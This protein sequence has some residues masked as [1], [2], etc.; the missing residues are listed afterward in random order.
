MATCKQIEHPLGCGDDKCC[1]ECN[2]R[3]NMQALSG[4]DTPLEKAY[5]WIGLVASIMSIL[6]MIKTFKKEK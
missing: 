5:T 1:D 3:V 6:V 4:L 2:G